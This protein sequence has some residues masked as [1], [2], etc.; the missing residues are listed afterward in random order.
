M[1]ALRPSVAMLNRWH[2]GSH[3]V[4]GWR[5]W[6]HQPCAFVLPP[7]VWVIFGYRSSCISIPQHPWRKELPLFHS[8]SFFFHGY[9]WKNNELCSNGA[10]GV[11]IKSCMEANIYERLKYELTTSSNEEHSNRFRL[12][13]DFIAFKQAATMAIYGNHMSACSF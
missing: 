11:V 1:Q 7:L 2:D 13:K 12:S 6:S 4:L 3:R 9:K 5:A 10:T 8:E